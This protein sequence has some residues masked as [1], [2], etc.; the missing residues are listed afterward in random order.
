MKIVYSR[1]NR[2]YHEQL[3]REYL[4]TLPQFTQQKITK[5]RRWED[6][7]LSLIGHIL[8]L[9]NLKEYNLPTNAIHNIGK[10]KY[11]KPY[12]KDNPIYF[13]IS[14]AGEIAVCILN[15]TSETG[16]DI[17]AIKPITIEDYKEC[18]TSKEWTDISLEKDKKKQ[19]NKFYNYWTKK[20]A[21]IKA[22]GWGLNTPLNTIE[23]TN[24]IINI[25]NK[26][27][28]VDESKIEDNYYCNFAI[29]IDQYS[30]IPSTP[31]EVTFIDL[32]K[33]APMK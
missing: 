30:P 21:I 23:T 13:N 24:N 2:Q 27:Y 18:L 15:P 25:K 16:I 3:Q 7:Q 19:L 31:P 14:H 33:Q 28:W 20:E 10:G 17:E 9:K 22:C 26:K 12:I 32:T 8:L 29:E 6:A 5:Y 1:I 11:H 4:H